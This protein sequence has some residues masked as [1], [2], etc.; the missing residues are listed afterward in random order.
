MKKRLRRES[1]PTERMKKTL[2]QMEK[3]QGSKTPRHARL[4]ETLGT[5]NKP[6]YQ[7][8]KPLEPMNKLLFTMAK[9]L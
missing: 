1:K 6:L 5:M 4:A 8:E 7:E 2:F 9:P 3:R